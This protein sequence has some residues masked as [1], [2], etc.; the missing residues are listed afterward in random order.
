M[1]WNPWNLTLKKFAF[2][3]TFLPWVFCDGD[4]KPTL[5]I[6]P[7]NVMACYS[8]ILH[9]TSLSFYNIF[10]AK[11]PGW[12]LNKNKLSF[13][14]ENIASIIHVKFCLFSHLLF[15]LLLVT[16]VPRHM[17]CQNQEVLITPWGDI[18]PGASLFMLPWIYSRLAAS[19]LALWY[20]N[21]H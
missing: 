18:F 11:I 7:F 14:R 5:W 19:D 12:I 4:R 3:L 8:D 13:F 1:D 17:S 16:C 10:S 21:S 2:L 20:L 15:C 6:K 9:N